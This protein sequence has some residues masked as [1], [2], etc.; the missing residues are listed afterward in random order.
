MNFEKI[1]QHI[2]FMSEFD[3][4]YAKWARGNFARILAVFLVKGS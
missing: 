2:A 3:P 4:A 1:K